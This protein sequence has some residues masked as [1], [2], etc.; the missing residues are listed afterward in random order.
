M[1]KVLLI[2]LAIFLAGC[3]SKNVPKPPPQKAYFETSEAKNYTQVVQKKVRG[4]FTTPSRFLNDKLSTTF[5]FQ[6]DK[7]GEVQNLK[8]QQS[9]GNKDFDLLALSSVEKSKPFPKPPVTFRDQEI[10]MRLENIPVPNRSKS[11]TQEY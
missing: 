3:A 4:N 6:V 11:F 2:G 1:G 8:V 10:Q 7:G 5:S 9:S